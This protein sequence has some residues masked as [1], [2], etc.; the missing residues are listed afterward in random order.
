MLTLRRFV[1]ASPLVAGL[2]SL[3][4]CNRPEPGTETG[5]ISVDG[6]ERTF[7]FHVPTSAPAEGTRMLVISL[8]GR[9]GKGVQQEDLTAFSALAGERGFVA[10]YPDG[11][12]K[13][14]AD[15]RGTSSADMQGIDDVAFISALIDHCIKNYGVD[16]KRVFV[17]GH[18][19]GS[20]MTNRLACE[21]STKIAAIGH[22]AG[23]IGETVSTSCNPERSVSVIGFHGTEDSFVPYAGGEVDKGAGGKV[24][25]AKDARAFWAGKSGCSME[26]IVTSLPDTAKDDGTTVE[27]EESVG[28]QNGNEV[29]LFTMTGGGHTWPG[30]T[31]DLGELLVGKVSYDIVAS[32]LML[33]FYEK[34]AMP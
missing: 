20:M 12:D 24:L 13:S 21:L 3:T 22:N 19:N 30:S 11:I 5:A 29:V 1:F 32:E 6:R 16:P 26:T 8:H 31:D 15:G 7:V 4:G 28:C 33:D 10:V 34:H 27:R 9:G 25:S 17:N 2:L 18:S 23:P 14:W